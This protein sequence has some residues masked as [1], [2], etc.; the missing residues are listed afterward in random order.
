[1]NM[2]KTYVPKKED[3]QP[4]WVLIDA[5]DKTLGRLATEIA[6][7]LRGKN[8]PFYTPFADMGDYIVVINAEK[9]RL[10]GKKLEQKEYDRYTGWMGGYKV[11]TAREM[12]EKHPTYIIEHAVKGMLPKNTL[13]RGIFKKLKVY[14]GPKHPHAAQV[15]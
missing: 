10:S 13:N 4:R 1:M 7:R 5:K 11:R 15:G 12:L 14:V 2:N 9:V 6:D 8:T 3:R